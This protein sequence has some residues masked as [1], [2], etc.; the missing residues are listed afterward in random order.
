MASCLLA[1]RISLHKIRY[2]IEPLKCPSILVGPIVSSIL[3]WEMTA[4]PALTQLYTVREH[5]LQACINPNL[6][7]IPN[8]CYKF[9]TT[10]VN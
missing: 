7:I 5:S 6:T 2:G 10:I 3:Q 8:Q 1:H 4:I 9:I